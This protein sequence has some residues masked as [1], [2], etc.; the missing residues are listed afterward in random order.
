MPYSYNNFIITHN[1]KGKA[2]DSNQIFVANHS[3]P[4]Y[5]Q[6]STQ[7]LRI[8]RQ[9]NGEAALIPYGTNAF[10]FSGGLYSKF[11]AAFV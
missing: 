10:V 7:F 11:R 2:C 6:L 5:V 1:T 4:Q 3:C 9:I 8:S